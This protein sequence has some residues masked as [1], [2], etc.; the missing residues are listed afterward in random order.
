MRTLFQ[1]TLGR[2]FAPR[3]VMQ[4]PSF[5]GID[6]SQAE[7]GLASPRLP[8]VVRRAR[9][10]VATL[11]LGGGV[12]AFGIAPFAPDIEDQPKVRVT[13]PLKLALATEPSAAHSEAAFVNEVRVAKGDS[14]PSLAGRLGLE[15]DEAM[16]FIRNDTTAR[17][18]LTVKTGK[19]VTAGADEEGEL[20]WLRALLSPDDTAARMLHIDRQADGTLK[21]QEMLQP[22]MRRTV[23]KSG[24]IQSSLFGATDAAGVPE[25]VTQQLIDVLASDI[26][27][28]NDL[29]RGDAFQ[30]VYEQL[31]LPS[32]EEVR[33]GRLLAL[34]FVN[35]GKKY[36]AVWYGAQADGNGSQGA[37]Y[38]FD[39]RSLRKA[40]LRTPVEFTRI[41]SGFGTRT[42]PILGYTRQH[43]GIDFAAPHGTGIRAAS[44][45]VIEFA[46]I[47][48]GYGNV[49]IIKHEGVY[50]TLYAHMSR[51][52]S[53]ITRGAKV[54]QGDIIGYVGSTGWSTGPHLHY[55]IHVNG[56]AVNP[57]TVALPNAQPIS[58]SQWG[59]FRQHAADMQRRIELAAQGN[60]GLAE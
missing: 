20:M 19:S 7:A 17:K 18:L 43:A 42:H 27:F 56:D 11:L 22:Y 10:V 38:T 33:S 29:R 59:N 37:Y 9:V 13:E 55:E 47:Q 30:V 25:A 60:L 36:Q 48:R 14:L 21:A 57:Q 1:R 52:G 58:P 49:V 3:A 2:F 6:F 53:G 50:S 24:A 16:S 32:G 51:F 40:F 26:D 8:A 44:D 4:D 5:S 54:N 15:D 41:S 35:G 45:G 39:G 12:T 23:M 28:Y 31:A 46:G 34:E